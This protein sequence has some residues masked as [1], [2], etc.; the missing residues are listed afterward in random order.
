MQW[1]IKTKYRLN[2]DTKF[3]S[4]V[5]MDEDSSPQMGNPQ[6]NQVVSDRVGKLCVQCGLKSTQCQTLNLNSKQVLL[7]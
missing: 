3:T 4:I 5:R 1:L 6:M 7:Q 2:T